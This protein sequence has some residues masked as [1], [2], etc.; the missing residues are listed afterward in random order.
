MIRHAQPVAADALD[1]RPADPGLTEL[2]VEQSRALARWLLREPVQRIL[3]SPAR[4]SLE[5]AQPSAERLGLEV[6]VDDRLRDL[7]SESAEYV[8]LEDERDRDPEQ[9]RARLRAY[10]TSPDLPALSRR[11][12]EALSE[13]VARHPSERVVAFCHGSVVNAFAASVL[14]LAEVVFL[15]ADYASAHR[16]RISRSGVRSVK[17]LNETAYL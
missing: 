2:G 3:S 5:T 12:D 14:G 13:W 10:R 17:S 7:H 11:V 15:D 4:R 16:F 9:Y 6:V 1:G 8:P